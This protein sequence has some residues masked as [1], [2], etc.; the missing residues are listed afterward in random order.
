MSSN[1]LLVVGE[2]LEE[3]RSGWSRPCP[4]C[5]KQ[6]RYTV[7]NLN[8]G[9]E[10]FLYCD[11]GSDFVLRDEDRE[12]AEKLTPA[13]EHPSIDSLRAVYERLEAE[14]PPCPHG[15]RFTVWANIQCPSCGYQFPYAGGQRNEA[16]RFFDSQLVWIEGA[17]AFRG[18]RLPSTRLAKVTMSP[19]PGLEGPVLKGQ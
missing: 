9:A 3:E 5:E 4:A 10:P 1:A 18:G 13:G 11:Q 14:L 15:G 7:L 19:G 17:T 2:I 12:A 6:I 16:V 8:S